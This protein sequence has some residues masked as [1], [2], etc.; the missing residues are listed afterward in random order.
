MPDGSEY[1]GEFKYGKAN[2]QGTFAYSNGSKY[3][4]GIKDTKFDG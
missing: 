3:V 2:G 4:G 1:V